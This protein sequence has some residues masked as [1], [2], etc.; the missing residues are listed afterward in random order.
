M[1][2]L[3]SVAIRSHRGIN[4]R[5]MFRGAVKRSSLVAVRIFILPRRA[6]DADVR[7]RGLEGKGSVVAMLSL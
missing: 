5:G 6:S 2:S 4:T 3:A 1:N 7:D